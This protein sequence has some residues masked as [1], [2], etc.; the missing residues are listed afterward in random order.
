ML[1]R[2]FPRSASR[3]ASGPQLSVVVIVHRMADQAER[4][5]IS[6]SPGYQQGV[7]PADYEVIVI[8]NASDQPLGEARA[9][10]ALGAGRLVYRWRDEVQPSPVPAVNAGV[11]M[12]RGA[13]VAI[14]IDGARMLSPGVIR[15]ALAALRA[16]PQA[17]VSVP[18][19]HLGS[20]LQQVAV[21]TGH[22]AAT[23]AAL[24]EGIGWPADGYR[25]FEVAVPS[26][27]SR[28]GFLRPQSES[29]FLALA[30]ARWQAIGGMDP[31]YDDHGGGK[32][33]LDL[34]KRLLDHPG[35]ALYLLFGEGSFHQFHGGVTTNTPRAER[36][37]IMAAINAQDRAIRG[38]DVRPPANPP[39]LFGTV[40]PAVRPFLRRSLD[41]VDPPAPPPDQGP[42]A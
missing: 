4:T 10:A 41:L 30:R 23:D 5:L 36:E 33:N 37:A 27:S 22:D 8:E 1:R 24:L 18:G 12:A 42:A 3:S 39:I 35:T 9:A 25:L 26:G 38:E 14:V 31:R 32:A 40:H 7:A 15:L 21:N 13:H 2:L 11:A 34:Y 16:D 29:N 17:A 19:Y 20:E 6:L 28:R